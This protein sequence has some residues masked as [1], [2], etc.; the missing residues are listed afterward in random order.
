MSKKNKPL[1]TF[2]G[3]YLTEDSNNDFSYMRLRSLSG[4]WSLSFRSDSAVYGIWKSMAK[5]DSSISAMEC[6]ATMYYHMTHTLPDEGFVQG[7]F[8]LL[9]S[10]HKRKE[11][12]STAP[13][14]EEQESARKEIAAIEALERQED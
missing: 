10:L 14:E 3:F 1:A 5:D 9:E 13:P 7:F 11:T 12:A 8:A 6:L 4:N 2:G